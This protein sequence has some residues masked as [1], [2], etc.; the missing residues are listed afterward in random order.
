M[1]EFCTQTRRAIVPHSYVQAASKDTQFPAALRM[2]IGSI[3]SPEAQRSLREKKKLS[4]ETRCGGPV[5]FGVTGVRPKVQAIP[6]IHLIE[7][8]PTASR[9]HSTTKT[10]KQTGPPS[11]ARGFGVEMP[12][13][14]KHGE[15]R[16]A[17]Y[18]GSQLHGGL[19]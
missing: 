5:N 15:T 13:L 12:L 9:M 3:A 14:R 4:W 7:M 11:A 16:R 19:Q 18:R 8:F 10:S 17:R 6:T 1:E 2:L